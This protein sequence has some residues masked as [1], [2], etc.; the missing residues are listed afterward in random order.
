MTYKDE[1]IFHKARLNRFKEPQRAGLISDQSFN[2]EIAKI[3]SDLQL[4]LAKKGDVFSIC[5]IIIF[6]IKSKNLYLPR[7]SL[8]ESGTMKKN[9]AM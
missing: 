4:R 3:T 1:T 5:V 7:S 6:C 8:T 9:G 2:I